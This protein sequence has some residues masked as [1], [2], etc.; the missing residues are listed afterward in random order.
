MKY[1]KRFLN[2][3]FF[4]SLRM[5]F[6]G[7]E[8]INDAN[9]DVCEGQKVRIYTSNSELKI[10]V[11][12]KDEV[13]D[14]YYDDVITVWSDKV[15]YFV[16]RLSSNGDRRLFV[17]NFGREKFKRDILPYET[18]NDDSRIQKIQTYNN[19]GYQVPF[20]DIEY[21]IR[22]GN[23][24]MS[25][26]DADFNVIISKVR[27]YTLVKK[28]EWTNDYILVY[29]GEDNKFYLFDKD[30]STS[31]PYDMIM[32][33]DNKIQSFSDV[34]TDRY[35]FKPTLPLIG[36]YL[37][38]E[39]ETIYH[40]ITSTKVYKWHEDYELIEPSLDGKYI[41]ARDDK[42][43]YGYLDYKGWKVTEFNYSFLSPVTNGRCFAKTYGQSFF[44]FDVEHNK[45]YGRIYKRVYHDFKEVY[46]GCIPM[47]LALVETY[48]G[49]FYIDR[50]D[51]KH[52]VPKK[53]IPEIE[54][55]Y[56]SV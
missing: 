44:L 29:I 4:I 52:L 28:D 10:F 35:D 23:G 11:F 37:S 45:E 56:L 18:F 51:K 48:E 22:H 8:R 38:E 15:L 55:C 54:E 13:L 21:V 9:I 34:L 6:S 47:E 27:N 1:I 17:Y 46:Y 32:F 12:K 36:I 20:G 24:F 14:I 49:V 53:S 31:L 25:F 43:K 5:F 50:Q 39:E 42:G 2:N 41:L 40:L 3:T 7:F 19:D 33:G 30:M 26:Y 16:K